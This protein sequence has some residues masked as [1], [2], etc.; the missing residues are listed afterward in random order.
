M[1]SLASIV[2]AANDDSCVLLNSSIVKV[3]RAVPPTS[4]KLYSLIEAD[5]VASWNTSMIGSSV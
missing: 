3:L 1:L 2:A 4:V 5:I